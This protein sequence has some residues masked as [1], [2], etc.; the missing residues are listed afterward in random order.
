MDGRAA[1]DMQPISRP[2][3]EHDPGTAAARERADALPTDVAASALRTSGSGEIRIGTAGWTDPTMTAAG[4]FYPPEANGAEERLRYY[5]SRFSTVEVDAPYYALP[6]AKNVELW[7]AR[8]PPG[9]VFDVKA[10][11]LMTG[12][13]CEVKRLPRALRDALPPALVA[14]GRV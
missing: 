5:A 13:A 12:H 4:V 1:A 7:A 2:T 3:P 10:N 8:T 6:V 14:K 11:A 9:F